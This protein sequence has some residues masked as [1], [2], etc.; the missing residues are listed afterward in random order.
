VQVIVL[1]GG[2]SRRFGSDKLAAL[3]PDGR[4]VLGRCLL[5]MP[6]GWDLVVVGPLRPVPSEVSERVRWVREL[7]PG[8]GPLAGIAAGLQLVTAAV[9]CVVPGDAPRAGEVL[10]LLVATLE[11]DASLAAAV[12]SDGEGRANPVLAAYRAGRLREAVPDAP[13]NV[14]ARTLLALA[15]REV[16]GAFEVRDVDTP[17]DLDELSRKP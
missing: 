15:H 1:A 8:G 7:P 17:E 9:V 12:L 6:S 16:R 4:S 13:A 10:P 5:G 2:S 11:Q 14:P 3:L